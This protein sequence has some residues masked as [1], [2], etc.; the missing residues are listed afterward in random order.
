MKFILILYLLNP[1]GNISERPFA[2]MADNKD[3][4][5]AG[6]AM[7]TFYAQSYGLDVR[8]SCEPTN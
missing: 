6:V 2:I 4:V 8:Y 1:S 5:L 3:C 7:S